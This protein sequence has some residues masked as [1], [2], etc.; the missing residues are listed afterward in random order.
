MT[1]AVI[2]LGS[3]LAVVKILT[4]FLVPSQFIIY[5]Q[6]QTL[7]QL[8]SAFATSIASMKFSALIAA[9]ETE[10]ERDRIFDTAV[11]LIFLLSIILFLVTV[12]FRAQI[13]KYIA[14]SGRGLEIAMLPLGAFAIAYCT[15][16]QAYFT[17]VGDIRRFG[18]NSIAV[19]LIISASTVIFTALY[20]EDG[21]MLSV[22][23]SPVVACVL[24]GGIEV[25]KRIPRIKNV[26]LSSALEIAGFTVSS[27]LT[28]VGYYF[29][30]LYVRSLYS[31]VVSP[32]EAGLLT[33][34]SRI[35]EVY[36]GVL[37]VFFANL[38]TKAYAKTVHIERFKIIRRSYFLFIIFVVP[39]FLFLASTT[40][41]WV[42]LLLSDRYVEAHGH[43][44]MQLGADMLKCLYWISIYYVIS[45]F[46]TAIYFCLE[47]FGLVIYV[48]T[49]VWNP[50]DSAKYAPQTAQM[51]EFAILLL[52]VN[53]IITYKKNND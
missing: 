40:S 41:L 19:V 27:I 38:L 34:S 33:A 15:L 42:P 18:R 3:S 44:S 45:K 17:G 48:L 12:F 8:Y 21:A 26:Q 36:M 16:I 23:V 47:L 43:M 25:C 29:A 13:E 22:G 5:G 2:R 51:I 11:F 39:G 35:S 52:L 1:Q 6:I 32:H 28:L 9:K 20:G 10:K 24:I 50:F 46:S 53:V 30:Q 4:V 14:V 31:Q 49:A 37:A 7:M